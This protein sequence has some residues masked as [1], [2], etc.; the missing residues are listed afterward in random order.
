MYSSLK[1]S[2]NEGFTAKQDGD[3]V[4]I[5]SESI[6]VSISKEDILK[7]PVAAM[8]IVRFIEAT[9]QEAGK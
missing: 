5:R 8:F 1:D 6:Y 9:L 2:N 7:S 4:D 3:S